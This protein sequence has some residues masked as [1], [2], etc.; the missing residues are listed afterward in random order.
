MLVYGE[1]E[2][3]KYNDNHNNTILI[4]ILSLGKLPH[5]CDSTAQIIEIVNRDND[6]NSNSNSINYRSENELRISYSLAIVRF[7]LFC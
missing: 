5:S 1:L 6:A 2:V 3:Y 7:I 4:L